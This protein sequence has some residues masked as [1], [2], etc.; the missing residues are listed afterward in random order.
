MN[1][2]LFLRVLCLLGLALILTFALAAPANGAGCDPAPTNLVAWWP[3][4]G[5]ANTLVG[6][7][8]G[9]L[10]GGATATAAGFDGQAFTFSG[11]NQYMQIADAAALRPTNFTIEAWV[12]F[13]SLNSP[14]LGGSPAGDQYIIFKQNSRTYDFEGIDISKTRIGGNDVFRFL[15]TSSAAVTAE[16]DSTATISTN[17]WYHIAAVRGSNYTQLYVN[18]ALQGQMTVSFAQNYGTL[19]LYFGTSGQSYWD[20]KLAGQ[21]DEVSLYNRPLSSNEIAAIYA[22]GSSGKCKGSSPPGIV[23]PPANQTV[24]VGSNALFNVT[25]SGTAPLSYQ[26]QFNSTPIAG[27]TTSGLSLIAVQTT[28]SGLYSIIIT[29]TAGAVTSSATLNV[30]TPPSIALQPL[31]LTNGLG[32]TA[33]FT[34]AASGSSPLTYQWQLNGVNL[35]NS[36]RIT[37]ATTT[38]LTITGLLATDTGNYALVA[39]NPVGSATSSPAMLTVIAPPSVTTPP[40]NQT[41]A[42]GANPVFTVAATGTAPLSYQWQNSGGPIAGATTSSLALSNVQL[43]DSGTYSVT[44]SNLIGSTNS[45]AT[46]TVLTPPGITV[47]P[48]AVTTNL[49][50]AASFSAGVSGSPTLFYQWRLNGTNLANGA[51]LTGANTPNLN[52]T[53]LLSSDAGNYTLF[54]SNLVGN[55]TSAPALLTII[56]PPSVTGQPLSQTNLAGMN[57]G[58]SVT[59]S[60]TAPLAFQWY[61]NGSIMTDGGNVFGSLSSTLSLATITTND[62]ANYQVIITNVAGAAT[63]SV[64]TLSVTVP[65]SCQMPPSGLIGWWPGEGNAN[66]IAYVDNGSLQGGA[67]ASAAGLVGNAFSFDGTNSYVQIPDTP[68]LDQNIFTVEAWVLFRSLTSAGLGGS[69]AGQQYIIFKQNTR[70]GDF[71]GLYLGKERGTSGDY[72]V[73]VV[74]SAADQSA[75]VISTNVAIATNTWY[76]LAAVRG[77]NYIQLYVNGVSVGQTAAAWAQNYGTLPLFFGS[78]GQSFWDHKLSGMLD[79]V[80]LYNRPLAASE[81]ASIYNA[82]AGGKCKGEVPPTIQV[83]PVGATIVIGGTI[84]F[85]VGVAG[86]APIGYQ[87][88]KDGFKLQNANEFSG[89]TASTLTVTNLQIADIGNYQVIVTNF[90]GSVTSVVASL[91][92]GVPPPNDNFANAI[93]L[94][95]GSSGSVAG[96]NANA[97]KEA[98][99]PN[100]AGNTGGPSV[101]VHVESAFDQSS[102]F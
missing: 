49:G 38:N 48:V 66:D 76:H 37:G 74:T 73:F 86:S 5:N 28:N 56:A 77:S 32:T 90:F 39:I 2:Y 1:R 13:T 25:A 18:G 88:Y 100:H 81:I 75:Q 91:N 79:E 16:I 96:N 35:A 92:S 53:G 47:P 84:N 24:A 20:H 9:V 59:V 31:G 52:I 44:I 22:A 61:K 101:W 63:S 87:W 82:K 15:V 78:S 21:L 42:V 65:G 3:G 69:P 50:G 97:T 98:G 46:L 57:V 23:T 10:E 34:A 102:D 41:A 80:S 83:Q 94:G 58:F 64:A 11:T 89:V 85:N 19:P 29:N 7:N 95:N 62:A 4:D 6:T 70:S 71:E 12:L 33:S 93:A 27:A 55:A 17:V 72:F 26:W 51:R 14:A 54:V 60:G 30:L 8:N 67:T 99:E 40:A 68:T 45:S 36:A 43:T